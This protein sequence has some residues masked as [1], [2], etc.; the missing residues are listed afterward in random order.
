M[1]VNAKELHIVAFNC[2]HLIEKTL[3]EFFFRMDFFQFYLA[4]ISGLHGWRVGNNSDK[5]ASHG[6]RNG[7]GEM[8]A[9]YVG[10]GDASPH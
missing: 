3:H 8:Q 9:W 5:A 1:L 6:H 10:V 2:Y 7:S 4:R